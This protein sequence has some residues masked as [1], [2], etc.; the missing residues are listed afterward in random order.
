MRRAGCLCAV[1]V[2]LPGVLHGQTPATAPAD[3]RFV[4]ISYV[5][6]AAPEAQTAVT[7]LR[8]YRDAS[9]GQDGFLD[10]LLFEQIGRPAHFLVVEAW[11]DR[12]A[13]DARDAAAER[14]LL[15]ALQPI[16]VSG[17]DQR[18]YK[19][20]TIMPASAATDEQTMYVIS[21]VDVTPNPEVPVLLR[22]QAEASRQEAGNIRFVVLQHT[23][24]ANHF[25]VIEA[26]RDQQALDAH[27]AA[28]HSRNYRDALQPMTG[29]PLDE[30]VYREVP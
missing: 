16:R 25:T 1:A 26:W 30:R 23:M 28:T 8:Q 24:R 20:L 2:L 11:R 19:V 10:L 13:F 21:H 14:Q 9:R 7:A 6:T 12:Q 17:S 3:T 29:S 27:A 22:R 4:A 18:P 5:E 15:E